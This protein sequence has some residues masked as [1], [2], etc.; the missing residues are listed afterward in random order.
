ME[1]QTYYVVG[2][3]VFQPQVIQHAKGVRHIM[4]LYVICGA[5]PYFNKLPPKRHDFRKKGALS[6]IFI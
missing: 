1:K 2:V 6:I 5:L 4:L 3:C